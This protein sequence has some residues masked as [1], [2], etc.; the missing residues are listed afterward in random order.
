[1]CKSECY[2]CSIIQGNT[3][4]TQ[5]EGNKINVLVD[6]LNTLHLK[7][8]CLAGSWSSTEDVINNDISLRKIT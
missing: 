3:K 5:Q 2:F 4:K 1:M 6:K 8:S 7:S